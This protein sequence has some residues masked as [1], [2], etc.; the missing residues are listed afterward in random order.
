MPWPSRKLHTCQCRLQLVQGPGDSPLPR[1]VGQGPLDVPGFSRTPGN[2]G[3]LVA[4]MIAAVGE[5]VVGVKAGV[6]L[7]CRSGSML[8]ATCLEQQKLKQPGRKLSSHVN[9]AQ[10]SN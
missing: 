7:L 8:L 4:E 6:S 5:Q 10:V 1:E 2:P 3:C 9:L